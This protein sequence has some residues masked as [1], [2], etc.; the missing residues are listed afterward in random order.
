MKTSQTHK[1]FS[2]HLGEAKVLTHPEDYLGH[3]WRD[4]INFWLF[5]DGLSSDEKRRMR[6]RYWALNGDVLD[7]AE[8]AAWA[9]AKEVVGVKV[10]NVFWYASFDVTRSIFAGATKELIA[11]HKLLGQGKTLLFLPL[12]LKS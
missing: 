5:I 10:A 1:R 6:D 8:D 11:H 3:N 12:C 2:D 7:S 9:S 4:V